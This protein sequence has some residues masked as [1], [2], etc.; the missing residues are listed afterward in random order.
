MNHNVTRNLFI[1]RAFQPIAAGTGDTQ[2]GDVI[3]AWGWEAISFTVYLGALAAGALTTLKVQY[4]NAANGSDM[5]D[6]P[7]SSLSVPQATGGGL[8]WLLPEIYRPTKR[9]LRAAVVRG[10]TGSIAIN[11]GQVQ[12]MRPFTAPPNQGVNCGNVTPNIIISP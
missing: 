1:D 3:D 11:S 2:Y 6:I 12:M 10:G 8:V 5:A 9:Y 7:N 4:G